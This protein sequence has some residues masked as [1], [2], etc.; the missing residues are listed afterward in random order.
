MACSE[1][2]LLQ[3]CETR[4]RGQEN[5]GKGFEGKWAENRR[6]EIDKRFVDEGE[7]REVGRSL[8]GGW[9]GEAVAG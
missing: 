9:E 6:N 2:R 8:R 1:R 7:G 5:Q 3:V 4:D